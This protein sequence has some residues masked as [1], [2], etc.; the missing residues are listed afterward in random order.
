M[1]DASVSETRRALRRFEQT[2]RN[3]TLSASL[4]PIV[5][6]MLKRAVRQNTRS[7]LL[8]LSFGFSL[9]LPTKEVSIRP[10]QIRTEIE[11]FLELVETLYPKVILEVGTANGGTLFLFTKLAHPEAIIISIDLPFGPFGGGY[12]EW[13]I[14]LYK[15]F[16]NANQKI[17]LIRADSHNPDTTQTVR[18]ILKDLRIDLLFIDGDHAYDGVR[19]DFETYSPLVRQGG[20]VAFHDIVP[21]PPEMVGGVPKFWSEV[22]LRFKS[23]EI[24]DVARQ[25]GYGIGVLHL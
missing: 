24:V 17:H 25:R 1:G 22:K 10:I 12:N 19:K 20:I 23:L 2:L 6:L 14:P 3:V 8:R 11:R 9:R 4:A 16:T 18:K 13:K 21:G 7:D 15:S 5:S